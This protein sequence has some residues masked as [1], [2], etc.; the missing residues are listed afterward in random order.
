MK[1]DLKMSLDCFLI[2]VICDK[3]SEQERRR[4]RRVACTDLGG[5]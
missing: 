1:R 3:A 5:P 2:D 4:R